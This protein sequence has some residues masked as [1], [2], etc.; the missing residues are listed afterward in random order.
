MTPRRPGQRRCTRVENRTDS[1]QFSSKDPGANFINT[2][3]SPQY[4]RQKKVSGTYRAAEEEQGELSPSKDTH[5]LLRLDLSLS[6][7]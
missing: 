7:S 2:L 1:R 5:A 4:N 6:S 3:S